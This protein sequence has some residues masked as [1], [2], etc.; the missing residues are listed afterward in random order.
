M[1]KPKYFHDTTKK[2]AVQDDVRVREPEALV[3]LAGHG[4]DGA[5][6]Q[7]V[8]S[9]DLAPDDRRDDLAEREGR[10][11]QHAHE[12]PAAEILVEQDGEEERER[13]LQ[14]QRQHEDDDVVRERAA[15]DL[16]LERGREVR[17]ADE[18]RELSEAVPVVQA[19]ARALDDGVDQ[20]HAVQQERRRQERQDQRPPPR[21]AELRVWGCVLG[22]ERSLE[23]GPSR[24]RCRLGPGEDYFQ[25]SLTASTTLC[26]VPRPANSVAVESLTAAPTSGGYA[27]SR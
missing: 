10:E 22:H 23:G 19:V 9:E 8:G 3:R 14:Q 13:E 18:V 2:T 6:Q 25:A 21:P 7:A 1:W 27:W 15:E 4:R 11:E 16:V 24:Q 5:V 26:G 17:E 12:R 20:E